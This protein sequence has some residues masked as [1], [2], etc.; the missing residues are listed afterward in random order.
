MDE[1][2]D[3]RSNRSRKPKIH[4]DDIVQSSGPSKPSNAPKKLSAAPKKPPAAPKKPSETSKALTKPSEKPSEK[5]SDLLDLPILDPIK[6]LCSQTAKL[7]IKAKKKAKSDEMSR[8][9][10]LGFQGVLKEIKPLKEIKYEPL[11]LGDHRVPKAN[12]PPNVDATDP[13]ALLDLFI[14]PAMY[15]TIAENTNLYAIFKKAP[16]APTNSSSRYWWPTNKNEIRV[17][18]G[19]LYY[20]GV[21]R[22]PNFRIYWETLKPNGPVHA[23]SK[24]MAL[25]CYENLRRFLHIS[26][27]ILEPKIE[28]PT[29]PPPPEPCTEALQP[30]ER[31]EDSSEDEELG[32]NGN[33]WWWRAEPLLSTFRT[34]CQLYLVLGTEVAIDE[35]MVRFFGCSSDTCK[36]PNKLI[37]QGYKIFALAENGYVWHFQMSSKQHRI[38]QLHK[39]DEL[40]PTSSI[41]LQM[42]RLLPKFENAPYVLYLDNYFTSIPLFSMLRKENIGAVGTARPSGIDFPALLIVLHKNWAT[43]LD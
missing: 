15:T 27:P 4:F 11:I 36:M 38:G 5:P 1:P 28:N 22:E 37:K 14:P 13:L 6:E 30:Q 19:I 21:H 18:F 12:I 35:I 26:K 40:T 17:L 24:H 16:T 32:D 20:M 34:A 7:N 31:P 3:R 25:N 9:I 8:L 29:P 10:K 42:A 43:K 39:V 33:V 23:I 41:V 2:T